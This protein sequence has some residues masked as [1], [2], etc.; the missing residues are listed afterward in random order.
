MTACNGTR[1]VR[2]LLLGAAALLGGCSESGTGPP[3]PPPAVT[4]ESFFHEPVAFCLTAG[5]PG[6]SLSLYNLGPD[7]LVWT[8]TRVPEGLTGL[9]DAEITLLPGEPP[10][11]FHWTW[12]PT[13]PVPLSDTLV[14]ITN[15]PV[16]SEI[17]IPFEYSNG[18]PDPSPPLAPVLA[19]PGDGATVRVGEDLLVAW[20]EVRDC[21][22]VVSYR[23]EISDSPGFTNRVFFTLDEAFA[24]LVP[25][26]EDVGVA[27]WRVRARNEA[28]LSGPWSPVRSWVIEPAP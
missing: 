9:D 13:D 27:Y 17:R 12:E 11:V 28:G 2:A 23:L 20:S 18:G 1:P 10:T 7:T 21:S 16:R 14:A 4:A 19:V 22:P 5:S 8:P 25:D 15:D 6:D 26:P 24:V 3:P